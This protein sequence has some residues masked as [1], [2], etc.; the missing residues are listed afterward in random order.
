MA[1]VLDALRRNMRYDQHSYGCGH[2]SELS[3]GSANNPAKLLLH[4]HGTWRAGYGLGEHTTLVSLVYYDWDVILTAILCRGSWQERQLYDL[5]PFTFPHDDQHTEIQFWLS[6]VFYLFAF[7]NFF[8]VIPQS[9]TA[10]QKQN[11]DWQKE[12]VAQPIATSARQ[13]AGAVFAMGAWLAICYSLWHSLKH[14]THMHWRKYPAKLLIII[15]LLA[16]RLGYGLVSAW[17]WNISI[18]QIGVQVGWPFGLGYAPLLLIIAVLEVAGFLE[19]NEDKMII[20]QRIER[21]RSYDE[22]LSITKKPSWWQK[23]FKDRYMS[24]EQRLRNMTGEIGGGRATP[25]RIERNIEMK[26]TTA[27]NGS[28]GTTPEDPFQDE[29][30]HNGA[31]QGSKT[32]RL[33]APRK[34]GNDAMSDRT[35]MTGTTLKQDVGGRSTQAQP[36]QM[37]R[38]MLDV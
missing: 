38:S 29:I 20:Q 11:T 24:D 2:R 37:I 28:D 4:A 5:D 13:K 3:T 15:A 17:N 25:R 18:F 27:R 30:L 16:L 1:V 21:G 14:Y 19:E 23:N 7:L 10:V 12:H 26:N 9:W 34:I 36:Q 6:L 33:Q 22:E 35:D 8:M 31:N 32:S